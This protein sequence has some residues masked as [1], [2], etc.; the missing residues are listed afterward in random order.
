MH[1]QNSLVVVRA[2]VASLILSWISAQEPEVGA[3]NDMK[4]YRGAY[5]KTPSTRALSC[6]SGVFQNNSHRAT[7]PAKH[8]Q[9]GERPPGLSC[10]KQCLSFRPENSRMLSI[11]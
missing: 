10:D 8:G 1:G 3:A 4:V 5:L 6:Q 7:P 9:V 2:Y 11:P